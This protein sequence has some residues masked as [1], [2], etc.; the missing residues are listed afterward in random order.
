MNVGTVIQI[1]EVGCLVSITILFDAQLCQIVFRKDMVLIQGVLGAT[2]AKSENAG[3]RGR[4]KE[5]RCAQDNLG[6]YKPIPAWR[7]TR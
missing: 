7:N 4:A 2:G 5:Q 1:G 3:E 6:G